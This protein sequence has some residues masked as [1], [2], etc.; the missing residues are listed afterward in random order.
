[1]SNQKPT[2]DEV[3][4]GKNRIVYCN[5]H[6]RPHA[7]GWCTVHI[8]NKELLGAKTIEEAYEECKTK[9]LKLYDPI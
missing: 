9:G 6:L 3:V 5:Q 7:T 1:M 8:R 4:F 2:E